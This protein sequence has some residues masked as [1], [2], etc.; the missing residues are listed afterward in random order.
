MERLL[1]HESIELKVLTLQLPELTL[2]L[3]LNTSLA[4][5][6]TVVREKTKL[7]TERIILR[8]S[9]KALPQS[10]TTLPDAGIAPGDC[11]R[12]L[13]TQVGSIGSLC[14]GAGD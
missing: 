11:I 1:R 12:C 10:E 3:P 8:H 5:L 7:A 2:Y 9:G 4:Q 6:Y 13:V 14:I